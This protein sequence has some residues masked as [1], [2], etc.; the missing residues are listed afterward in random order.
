MK[1]KHLATIAVAALVMAAAPPLQEAPRARS[2]WSRLVDGAKTFAHN[3]FGLVHRGPRQ[4]MPASD[5]AEPHGQPKKDV[6]GDPTLS[7]PRPDSG[8]R[9]ASAFGAESIA[10]DGAARKTPQAKHAT[11][12]SR[13]QRKSRTMSEFMAQEKP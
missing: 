7:A 3:P 11:W 9:R 13:G 12:L 8:A 5:G 2:P 10:A 6:R 4:S 1:L